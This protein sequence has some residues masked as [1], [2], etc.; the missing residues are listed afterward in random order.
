MF[1][2]FLFNGKGSEPPCG[3]GLIYYL[4]EFNSTYFSDDWYIVYNRLG[5]GC[6]VDFPIIRLESKIRW[7]SVVYNS[8]GSVKPKVFTE[9]ISVTLVKVDVNYCNIIFVIALWR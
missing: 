5:D 4:E 7:S 3:R 9:I 8:D 2:K 1:S 6:K